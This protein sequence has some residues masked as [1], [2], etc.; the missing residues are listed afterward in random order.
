[1]AAV[2]PPRGLPTNKEFLRFSTTRFISRSLTPA[3]QAFAVAAPG[4]QA[5]VGFMTI[6]SDPLPAAIH[7][8]MEM[9]HTPELVAAIREM[10]GAYPGLPAKA[11]RQE[12]GD[13]TLELRF[14]P[15]LKTKNSK[16]SMLV[17]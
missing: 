10:L 2:R 12:R 9:A 3:L 4:G 15:R 13:S 6:K 11:P 1:M 7:A 16:G 5:H 17:G 8:F 14:I